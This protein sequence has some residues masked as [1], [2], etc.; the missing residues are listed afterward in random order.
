MQEDGLENPENTKVNI[1]FDRDEIRTL[2]DLA[3]GNRPRQKYYVTID[4]EVKTIIGHNELVRTIVHEYAK[5]HSKKDVMGSFNNK[6]DKMSN[7]V[8]D[9]VTHLDKARYSQKVIVC[10]GGET[11]YC[12]NQWT[13]SKIE[14]FIDTVKQMGFNINY[15]DNS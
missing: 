11:L 12:N 8:Y 2:Y 1:S 14:D 13:P 9:D 3:S 5:K 6:I 15:P 10:S 7:V 4:G